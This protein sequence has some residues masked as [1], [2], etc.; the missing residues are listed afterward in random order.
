VIGVIGGLGIA[1]DECCP[2]GGAAG[3][4]AVVLLHAGVADR[5]M[6]DHRFRA[7]ARHHRVIRY[8]RPGHGA[9]RDP[10]PRQCPHEDLLAVLDA[11]AVRRAVLAGCSMGGA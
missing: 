2:P 9:S 3:E 4:T 10:G 11:L 7:L 5:R 8:D 6:R 1:Y